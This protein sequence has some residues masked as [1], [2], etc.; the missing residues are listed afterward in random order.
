M[1]Q[2]LFVPSQSASTRYHMKIRIYFFIVIVFINLLIHS[3]IKLLN[4]FSVWAVVDSGSRD[5]I[6]CRRMLT[7]A[8]SAGYADV[9]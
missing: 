1:L 4:K 6:A 5:C 2:I 3:Y 8:D 9:C 7:Y